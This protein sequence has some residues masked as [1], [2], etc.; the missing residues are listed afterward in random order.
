MEKCKLYV[1]KLVAGKKWGVEGSRY[2]IK[3][4]FVA[5]QVRVICI[6]R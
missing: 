4:V 6:A 1:V 5:I 3:F 2:S